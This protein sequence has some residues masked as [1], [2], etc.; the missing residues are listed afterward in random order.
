MCGFDS[1]DCCLIWLFPLATPWLPL[2]SWLV[3]RGFPP[4][5]QGCAMCHASH[6]TDQRTKSH[7]S[8]CISLIVF[9]SSQVLRKFCCLAVCPLV[10]HQ[11]PC[12]RAYPPNQV[13]T[14]Q[15]VT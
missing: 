2:H 10:P 1:A 13:V 15:M 7:T 12:A 5:Q 3:S 9:Y 14:G 4:E 8:P 6:T 11:H